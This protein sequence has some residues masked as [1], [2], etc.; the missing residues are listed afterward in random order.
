MRHNFMFRSGSV[1]DRTDNSPEC[2]GRE[3]FVRVL[4]DA[5][6]RMF[7]DRQDARDFGER[8]GG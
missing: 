3:S 2:D 8:S 5:R 6:M 4:I 1:A 7:D